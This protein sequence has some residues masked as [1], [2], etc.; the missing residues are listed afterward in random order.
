V[1][2]FDEIHGIQYTLD[3]FIHHV[4]F[5]FYF[6]KITVSEES[7]LGPNSAFDD[8]RISEK[9]SSKLRYTTSVPKGKSCYVGSDPKIPEL[10]M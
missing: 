8:I 7:F 1:V 5:F 10:V 2:E 9:A 4:F 3:L 6:R